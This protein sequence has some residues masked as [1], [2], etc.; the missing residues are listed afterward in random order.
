MLLAVDAGIGL[1]AEDSRGGL[2]HGLRL[3]KDG[4]HSG[5]VAGGLLPASLFPLYGHGVQPLNALAVFRTVG[6]IAHPG[7]I[8]GSSIQ[9]VVEPLLW[10]RASCHQDG[11]DCR[12]VSHA[13]SSGVVLVTAGTGSGGALGC[14]IILAIAMSASSWAY[15]SNSIGISTSLR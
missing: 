7:A 4:S 6:G 1:P 10:G 3:R 8:A 13:S 12:G 15:S 5:K 9:G 2:N 11:Q 14:R